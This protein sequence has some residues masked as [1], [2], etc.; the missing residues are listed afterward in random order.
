M[1][2]N[3]LLVSLILFAIS[4]LFFVLDYF[5]YHYFG[6]DLKFHKEKKDL[7]EK[8][9]VTNLIGVFATMLLASSLVILLLALIAY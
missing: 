9:F 5:M 4:T 3:L 2:E 6:K 8:P 7:P 1:K